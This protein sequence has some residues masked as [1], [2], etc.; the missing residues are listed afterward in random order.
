[1]AGSIQRILFL[2]V[3]LFSAVAATPAKCDTENVEKSFSVISG[4]TLT[5]E[6]DQGSIKVETGDR[7]TVE[8]LVE[9]IAR[10]QKQLDGFKVNLAQKGN[11]IFVGG[12]S[13]WNSKVSVKFIIK[14][15]QEF[16][17]DLT[18][19]GGAIG[20]AD[21]SG[22]VK[23]KTKGG[24][25]R[26][27]NVA[28]G[29]VEAKTAGGNI[30]VGD[31]AGNLKVDTSGGNIG[32][33]KIS[34]KS[35]IDTSGGSIT[36]AQGGSDVKA[37]T[38]GGS[39]KIGPVNGKVAV[40]TSGG[41]IRIGMAEDDVIAKTSG[42][43]IVVEGSK[44]SVT[45]DS[46]G[47][48]L[49][50]GSSSGP[51][52]AETSGGSIKILQARGFIEADTS[53]GKIDAEMIVDEKNVDTH[54][55]LKTSG[56]SIT[57]HMPGRLAASVSATL[58]ITRSARRDYRIFSDFPLTIKG[59]GSRKITANGDINGGGDKIILSTTNGD[60]HIKLLEK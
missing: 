10:N 5:I 14:V 20:V 2:L 24:N 52:K 37:E 42:G 35:S 4:G 21:I 49:F 30:N 39:I 57:L 3:V 41:G 16:N 43:A 6:S 18:T 50:V 40:D 44:G 23:V 12:E 53:G 33:G 1:M 47:G 26:I 17:L 59:E 56:G 9:K 45:I 27:G 13:D 19:G 58:K 28:Q 15:P 54:V 29:N 32:L 8:V 51:V 38:S 46:S 55:D 48:N 11:D 31:V 22:E 60:I 36:L 7:Q 34:G 25:I